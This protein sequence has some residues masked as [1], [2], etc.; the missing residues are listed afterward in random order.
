M[1]KAALADL[2]KKWAQS[3]TSGWVIYDPSSTEESVDTTG[4]HLTWLIREEKININL[5]DLVEALYQALEDKSLIKNHGMKCYTCGNFIQL[6]EANQ[7]DG[8][9]ICHLCRAHHFR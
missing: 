7:L 2:I 8:R 6:A 3:H 5:R 9:F 4:S 1:D